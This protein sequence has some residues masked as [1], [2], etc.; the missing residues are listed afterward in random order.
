MLRPEDGAAPARR[1]WD[2]PWPADVE[3]EVDTFFGPMT[4]SSSVTLHACAISIQDLPTPAQESSTHV[5][6]AF[7]KHRKIQPWEVEGSE[8][9]EVF[10]WGWGGE[11]RLGSGSG[12][13]D[14]NFP[15]LVNRVS[16]VRFVHAA[17]GKR[18]SLAVT[19]VGT[20]GRDI[21]ETL[22]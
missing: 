22:L 4:A 9:T 6:G 13:H 19:E 5:L 18:H 21:V 2:E 3:R 16:D 7:K 15:T 12:V 14:K 20:S 11:G 10:A 1:R 17:T 8:Q